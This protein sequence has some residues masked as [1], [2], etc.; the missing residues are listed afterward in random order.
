MK[1]NVLIVGFIF[2][3]LSCSDFIIDKTQAIIYDPTETIIITERDLQKS[4]LSGE[5]KNLKNLCF[6]HLVTMQASAINLP[7]P[8]VSETLRQIDEASI[9]EAG[10]TLQEFQDEVIR[11]QIVG[12]MLDFKVYSKAVVPQEAIIDF[13]NKNPEFT[14]P[15]YYVKRA[16]LDKNEY[17]KD[18]VKKMVKERRNFIEWEEP[19]WIS[20]KEIAPE[21]LFLTTLAVHAIKAVETPISFE[22]YTIIACEESQLTPLEARYQTIVN[23]LKQPL[24]RKLFEQYQA[25]IFNEATYIIYE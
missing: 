3:T 20:K 5:P 14:E 6:E 11:Y 18:D 24:V 25:E 9:F 4:T 21:K 12:T 8:D 2:F 19:F 22:L 15:R 10:Y 17:S 1:N 16:V 7:K 23:E 13:F